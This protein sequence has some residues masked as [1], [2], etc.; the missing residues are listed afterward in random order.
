MSNIHFN[1]LK[2]SMVKMSLSVKRTETD[3]GFLRKTGT[4]SLYCSECFPLNVVL[5]KLAALLAAIKTSLQ[6]LCNPVSL[7]QMHLAT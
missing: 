2:V 6:M 4:N 7:S 3:E 1:V 5:I